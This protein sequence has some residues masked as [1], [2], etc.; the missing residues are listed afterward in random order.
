MFAITNALNKQSEKVDDS[1]VNEQIISDKEEHLNDDEDPYFVKKRFEI[2]SIALKHSNVFMKVAIL[3]VFVVFLNISQINLFVISGNAVVNTLARSFFTSSHEVPS[4]LYI[5]IVF[6]FWF[7]STL[8]SL[9]DLKFLS[10]FSIGITFIRFIF[11]FVILG[12]T[13]YTII[14]YGVSSVDEIP[15]VDHSYLAN[16]IGNSIFSF[17]IH[18]SLPGIFEAFPDQKRFIKVLGVSFI[19]FTTITL[20]FAIFALITFAKYKVCTL[21]DFPSA[22]YVYT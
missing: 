18:H 19:I 9:N 12:M 2:T 15:M 1:K 16:M 7:V 5:L 3:L 11:F 22:I 13:L 14:N 4:Y 8:L 20:G 6:I 10:K 21:E 17:M